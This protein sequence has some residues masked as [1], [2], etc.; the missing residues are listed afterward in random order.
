MVIN[1]N[2]DIGA[3]DVASSGQTSLEVEGAGYSV[4]ESPELSTNDLPLGITEVSIDLF[5]GSNQPNPFWIGALQFFVHAP[6]ANLYNAY[7]GQIELTGIA[8]DEF[9]TLTFDLPAHIASAL[10]GSH[11]DLQLRYALNVNQGSGPYYLDN[12]QFGE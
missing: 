4:V 11:D 12:I 1:G 8:Q 3:S 7:V 10:E 2:S 9:T 6:S 5:V